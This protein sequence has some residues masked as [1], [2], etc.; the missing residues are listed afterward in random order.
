M[1]RVRI[2]SSGIV[3]REYE[4]TTLDGVKTL[5]ILPLEDDGSNEKPFVFFKEGQKLYLLEKDD[6]E[7]VDSV[8]KEL[9]KI[10]G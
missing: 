10:G 4:S 7:V 2:D 3:S 1:K 8:V 9:N 5:V 6:I